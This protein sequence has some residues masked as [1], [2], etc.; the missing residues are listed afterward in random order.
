MTKIMEW[1]IADKNLECALY[2][3]IKSNRWALTGYWTGEDSFN[4][5]F[6]NEF[7]KKNNVSYCVTVTSGT[8]ALICALEAL[9][10]GEG[11]EVIVPALTW[12]ATATAVLQ[13]NAKP[14]FVDA[15]KQ[16]YCIDPDKIENAITDKTKAIIAV[17]L[18]GSMADMDR[19]MEIARIHKLK[20]IEDNA[21]THFS[22]WNG[23]YAGTIA[24]IGTFS[25]QQGKIL[26]SGEGG[27]VVT[28]DYNLYRKIQ[29]LKCDSRAYD[30]KIKKEYGYMELEEVGEI[31][32]TNYNLSEFQAAILLEN[33]KKIDEQNEIRRKNA[34]YLSER[35]KEIE[36]IHL[37]TPYPNNTIITYYGFVIPF[38]K[39]KFNNMNSTEI[40]KQLREKLNIGSFYMHPLYPAVHK[41]KLFCP[42]T[43]KRYIKS[44]VQTE[45]YWRNQ[46]F[47]IAEEASESTIF[48]LHSIL[49]Q[50]EEFIDN[51]VTAF[52]EIQMNK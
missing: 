37:L 10:I 8:T 33:L 39:S 14:V 26:T 44:V 7:A 46:S 20:V 35:L 43:N 23:K 15:C 17:H 30:E 29:Q 41:S 27:A 25:F 45:E 9:D 47:P 21:Q 12:V 31:H 22:V 18:C 49:L 42:W 34:I 3:V 11:D 2:D 6:E 16:T 51:I 32:G 4:K 52:K 50:D 19:I 36:G 5:K 13:V 24:D 28:N 40:I 38:D 1:P 48:M